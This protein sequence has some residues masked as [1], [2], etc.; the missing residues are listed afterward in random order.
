MPAR[1]VYDTIGHGYA[2]PRQPDPR[3]AA[4]LAAA[5][6]DAQTV[7]NVGAGTGSYEPLDRTVVAL[8]P[9]PVMLA[10]RG[11]G[12]APAVCG[13]AEALPFGAGVFDAVQG[14]LTVHH[15]TDRAAGL[16]ECARVARDRVV[17]LTWDPAADGFWLVQDYL[18][19]FLALDREQF[20]PISSYHAAF[21]PGAHVHVAP[22]PVPRDCR[23][24]FLGAYWARPTAYLDAAVRAGISSF[25]RRGWEAGLDRLRA[26][27]DS[28]AWQARYAHLR[29]QSAL[30]IGYRII[31]A[32]LPVH[33]RPNDR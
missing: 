9:S 29:T 25:A 26:D 32:Q 23:D 24:G 1:A 22:L 6:G 18:P 27:L 10:Q 3:I 7:L 31:I 30:D 8:E 16:A 12:S 4:R 5:L 14:I 19:E 2:A 13:R 20:A 33:L 11:R 17:L 28:G 21:G 15:W